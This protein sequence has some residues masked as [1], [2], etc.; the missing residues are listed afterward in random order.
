MTPW[1]PTPWEVADL[2]RN[3]QRQITGSDGTLVTVC[4]HS[5]LRVLVPVMEANAEHIVRC[6]NSHAA[7]VDALTKLANEATGFVAHADQPTHGWTNIRVLQQR[8]DEAR[9]ALQAAEGKR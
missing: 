6:V 1:T 7:L 8:I 5:C 4:A 9:A 2:D 3:D